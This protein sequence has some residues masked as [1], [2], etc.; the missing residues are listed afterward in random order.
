[1]YLIMVGCTS[2]TASATTYDK[3]ICDI[4]ANG[5]LLTVST[6]CVHCKRSAT[7]PAFLLFAIKLYCAIDV[8]GHAYH[9][10]IV[11]VYSIMLSESLYDSLGLLKV[12]VHLAFSNT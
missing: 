9:T 8:N 12:S 6:S 5:R 11:L 10:H 2:A 4:F 7:S 3:F 1:M